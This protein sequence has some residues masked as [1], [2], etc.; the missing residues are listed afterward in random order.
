MKIQSH[1]S[2]SLRINVGLEPDEQF[3]RTYDGWNR[4]ERGARM[5]VHALVI[6]VDMEDGEVHVRAHGLLYNKDG[7]LGQRGRDDYL[8][9]GE[10]TLAVQALVDQEWAT[11]KARIAGVDKVWFS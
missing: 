5:R 3:D 4:T 10:I 8:D 11:T 9:K 1:L 6:T 2:G 7:A